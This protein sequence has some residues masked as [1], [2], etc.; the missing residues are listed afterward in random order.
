MRKLEC[1]VELFRTSGKE[2]EAIMAI[3]KQKS[4]PRKLVFKV[5][6]HDLDGLKICQCF[7]RYN[8]LIQEMLCEMNS[9]KCVG[10]DSKVCPV[11]KSDVLV[12]IKPGKRK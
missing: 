10:I 11:R 1:G 5:A 4:R 9:K 12:S 6:E 2:C 8:L 7:S 3:K